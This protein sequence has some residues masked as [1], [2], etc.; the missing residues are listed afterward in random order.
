MLLDPAFEIIRDTGIEQ[1]VVTSDNIDMPG[2][3]LSAG[4]CTVK[5]LPSGIKFSGRACPDSLSL[6]RAQLSLFSSERQYWCVSS[7]NLLRSLFWK[8]LKKW[9]SETKSQAKP[10]LLVTA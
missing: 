1:A 9:H 4:Y 3:R 6:Y 7:R 5:R 2:H 10:I 8:L